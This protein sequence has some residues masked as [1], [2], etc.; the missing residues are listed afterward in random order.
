M[1]FLAGPL[2]GCFWAACGLRAA[3]HIFHICRKLLQMFYQSAVASALFYGVA[4]WGGNMKKR[5][6]QRLD[7]LVWQAGSMVD[8]KLDDPGSVAV[9]TLN[10]LVAILDNE[11][12]FL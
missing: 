6:T 10:E 1:L 2:G 5:D 9:R 12:S 11:S 3:I 8:L 4:C 7:K